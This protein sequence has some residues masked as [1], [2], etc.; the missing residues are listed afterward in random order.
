M[1]TTMQLLI[2]A[3]ALGVIGGVVVAVSEWTAN[4][5]QNEWFIVAFIVAAVWLQPN[6]I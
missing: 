3:C 5:V 4:I 2:A 6:Y 1:N